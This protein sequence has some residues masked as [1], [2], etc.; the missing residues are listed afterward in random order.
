MILQIVSNGSL[1]IRI[2]RAGALA[3]GLLLALACAPGFAALGGDAGSVQSDQVKLKVQ[4][5]TS[6]P[7]AG[8]TIE[9]LQLP[10]GTQ[11]REFVSPDARV[12][13]VAWRGPKSP[14]LHSLLGNYYP[15]FA[16]GASA[17]HLGHRHLLV[18][19]NDLVVQSNGRM[20][21]FYGRAYVP[22]LLPPNFDLQ[23]IH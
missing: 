1:R 2:R 10:S 8:Y 11:V 20:R 22:S 4:R 15:A 12:F 7:A 23:E 3:A 14:D 19:Q 21:A 5:R 17:S 6:A 9:H 18:R 16:A 13:A